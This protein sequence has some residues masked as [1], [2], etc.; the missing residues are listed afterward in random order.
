MVSKAIILAVVVVAVIVVSGGY[1]V[2]TM[3]ARSATIYITISPIN[4]TGPGAF[5]LPNNFTVSEGE[6]VTLVVLNADHYPHELAIPQFG[7]NTG[8]IQS[9][10]IV[11]QSFV[12]NESGT[13]V[14][15]QP[16]GVCTEAANACNSAQRTTGNMTVTP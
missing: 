8:L 13:F 2:T 5:F 11:K 4:G 10:D 1:Y 9:G 3:S 14:Y 16:P 15:D 12:P 6:H 7:V